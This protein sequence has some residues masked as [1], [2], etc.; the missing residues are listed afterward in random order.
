VAVRRVGA[1]RLEQR[2]VAAQPVERTDRAGRVGHPDVDVQRADGGRP[3]VAEQPRDALVARLVGDFRVAL[4]GGRV[5]ARRD[6]PRARLPHRRAQLRQLADG[7]LDRPV[8]ARDE[9]DLAAVQLAL[10]L[11][12]LELAEP[13]D[14]LGALVAQP[15]VGG[16]DDEQLL[17]Q[18][19]RERLSFAEVILFVDH[20]REFLTRRGG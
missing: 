11:A 12:A 14:D 16:I 3:S 9:L 2:Q 4:A 1:Q 18:P 17:L 10:D 20:Q 15:P 5:R 13:L 7:G 8:D 6:E 19:E